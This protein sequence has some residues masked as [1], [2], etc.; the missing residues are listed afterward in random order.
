MAKREK[1]S[2]RADLA[3][4]KHN[5]VREEILASAA[6]LFSQLGYRAVT[7]DDIASSLGYTKSILYYYFSNKNEILW[8][9]YLC[10]FEKYSGDLQAILDAKLPSDI[11]LKSMI[12]QHALNV[13]RNPEWAAIYNNEDSELNPSQRRQLSRMKRDYDAV[14]EKIFEAGVSQKL[15]RDIPRHVAVS[16]ILGMCNWL[17]SW[18]REKGT[19]AP[20]QIADQFTT[21]LS[22]G[23]RL[24]SD[25]GGKHERDSVDGSAIDAQAS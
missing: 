3:S 15:F 7:M 8:Q 22:D 11:T 23:Y 13:M 9:I 25:D 24:R 2:L 6:K 21:L 16:G 17:Y 4:R 18:F 20:E 1:R 5:L 10:S 14:F 12:R 19:L